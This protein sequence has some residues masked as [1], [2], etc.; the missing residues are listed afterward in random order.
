M[1]GV[2]VLD[3][4]IAAL[5]QARGGKVKALG[6]PSVKFLAPLNPEQEFDV[7]FSD[8]GT[9]AVAFEVVSEG[10]TLLTGSLQYSL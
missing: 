10:K 5:A 3:A 8:K 6:F 4:V 9:N 1:P 2:V 7:R